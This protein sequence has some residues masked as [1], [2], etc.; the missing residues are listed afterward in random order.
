MIVLVAALTIPAWTN[1]FSWSALRWFGGISYSLYLWHY[2]LMWG[3][4]WHLRPLAAALAVG[5]AYASTRWFEEPIRR[6]R[7]SSL[8]ATTAQPAEV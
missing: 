2:M 6:R 8:P 4:G 3:F 5:V 7:R 1:I